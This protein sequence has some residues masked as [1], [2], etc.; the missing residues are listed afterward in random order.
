[1]NQQSEIRSEARADNSNEHFDVLIVGAGIS[2]IDAAYHL[3]TRLPG[4]S[5]VVIE[6]AEGLG[7]TWR[8][9]R[10]P[11]IRTDSDLYTFG[12]GW[13]PWMG[14]TL[15]SAE[16]ITAYLEEAVEEQSLAPSIRYGQSLI[17]AD[18]RETEKRWFLTI[19]E[20]ATGALKLVTCTFLWMC[21]GYYDHRQGYVP[22][23]PGRERFAGPVVHPQHWPEDL[24]TAGKRVAVIGSGATA[25]TLVPALAETAGHVTIVQRTPTYYFP[26]P[27]EHELAALLRPL[28]LPP[29]WFHEIMRRQMF[30]E[31]VELMRRISE[32]PD[33]I[34]REF[35]DMA[36][37]HL[38][39]ACPVEP[40]FA[41]TYRLWRQRVA[42][43]P[44]G[45]LFLAVNRGDVSVETGDIETFT[46][47]GL[48]M[49][50]GT[51]VEADII[52][53]ATG[54]NLQMMG[55]VPFTID[56]ARHD[57]SKSWTHRAMMFTGAP[58]LAWIFGYIRASWTLRAD[59]VSEFVCRL[60]AYMEE[61][62]ATVAEPRLRPEDADMPALPFFDPE[63]FNPGYITRALDD[64]P[65]N[66]DRAPWI[67]S[68][69]FDDE[70]RS[71]PAASLTDGT[72]AYR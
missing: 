58:N 65:R 28:D 47:T 19:E 24:D 50:D 51:E 33:V 40:H 32:E 67:V 43:I 38:G 54:L 71:I 30:R 22:D 23:Y 26:R 59:L 16:E 25:A 5:F 68:H 72:I 15:A 36:R 20:V 57:F 21:Q 18:W 45:D 41:P 64:L 14:K 52:V 9:H 34:R 12:Y 37:D 3:K 8:T 55:G 11:G 17:A 2:G 62:G 39:D 69:D 27:K 49:K 63:D 1:M 4:K 35:L 42:L 46:E 29:E 44:E 60:L 48:T 61:T 6:R 10:F 7:G 31:R 53:S 13:K 66:G 70:R 56:G